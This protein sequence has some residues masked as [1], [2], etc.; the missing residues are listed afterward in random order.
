MATASYEVASGRGHWRR[1]SDPSWRWNS[2][3]VGHLVGERV[4]IVSLV[5][6]EYQDAPLQRVA[7]CVPEVV[8]KGSSS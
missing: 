7:A 4:E 5:G 8:M 6:G 1:F 3:G 2:A